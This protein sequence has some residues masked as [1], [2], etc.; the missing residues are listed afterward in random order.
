MYFRLNRKYLLYVLILLFLI[1]TGMYSVGIKKTIQ[2]NRF[3]TD[4]RYIMQVYIPFSINSQNKIIIYHK[5]KIT[6][7]PVSIFLSKHKST[8]SKNSYVWHTDHIE[9]YNLFGI[10][11]NYTPVH[12]GKY[13]IFGLIRSQAILL[14]FL[15]EKMKQDTNIK[16]NIIKYLNDPISEWA[17]EWRIEIQVSYYEYFLKR[18]AGIL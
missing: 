6:K 17:I 1:L 8:L 9:S 16:N 15:E 7:T 11:H 3:T 14:E 5:E 4:R 12:P 13:R 18:S 10:N 2:T